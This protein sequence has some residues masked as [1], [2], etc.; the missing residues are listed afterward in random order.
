MKKLLLFAIVALAAAGWMSGA[1]RDGRFDRFMER[2]HRQELGAACYYYAG[3]LYTLVN[4]SDE[5]KDNFNHVLLRYPKTS[6]APRAWIEKIDILSDEGDNG[7]IVEESNKFL[8]QYPEHSGAAVIRR[9]IHLIEQ[10]Y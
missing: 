10:G 1:V 2:H 8:E 7:R 4:R 5:A 6:Y 3:M 9:K